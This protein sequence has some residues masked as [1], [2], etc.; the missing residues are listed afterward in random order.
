MFAL[1]RQLSRDV[2]ED[3]GFLWDKEYVLEE[4]KSGYTLWLDHVTCDTDLS[5]SQRIVLA[6]V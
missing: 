5:V 1:A 4:T 3:L 6:V 2:S